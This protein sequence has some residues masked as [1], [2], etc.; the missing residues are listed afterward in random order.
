MDFESPFVSLL[1]KKILC[2]QLSEDTY[3]LYN[4]RDTQCQKKF[5]SMW[6]SECHTQEIHGLKILESFTTYSKKKKKKK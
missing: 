5:A 4:V 6:F 1:N 2:I 3:N